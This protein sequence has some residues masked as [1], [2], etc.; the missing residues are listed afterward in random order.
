M[1]CVGID[2]AGSGWLAVWQAGDGL[3]FAGYPTVAA[4]ASALGD[5]VVLGVTFRSV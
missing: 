5:V 1:Q 3:Q 4:V 2:G